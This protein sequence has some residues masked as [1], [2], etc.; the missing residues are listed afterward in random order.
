MKTAGTSLRRMLVD[1]LG[2]E[3]V[4]PNDD[5][6]S[7]RARGF[8]PGSREF[9]ELLRGGETH[10][11]SVFIG[12]FPFALRDELGSD[13]LTVVLLREPTSRTLSM[14][15]HRQL[16]SPEYAGASYDQLLDRADF[17]DRQIRDYQTKVMGFDSIGQCPDTVDIAFPV[18]EP[19][20]ATAVHNLS[21]VDI[22]GLTE[23]FADFCAR[24][25]SITGIDL[26]LR[27]D[28]TSEFR[29]ELTRPQE[30]RIVEL[31]RYDRMLYEE[32]RSVLRRQTGPGSGET[33]GRG[34]R[35]ALWR[36]R[37]DD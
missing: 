26:R 9:L 8:Y 21:R 28:N 24:F 1:A 6:L 35:R 32:A 14:L 3:L 31:T 11:A 10:G 4:Y 18:D 37:S 16:K 17:V 25:E 12:H 19:R 5:D 15:K 36:R 7:R 33:G 34:W 2:K 13:P 29:T 20:F 30:E 27:R 22:L 23:E